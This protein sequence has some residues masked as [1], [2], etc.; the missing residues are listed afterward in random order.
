M[1]TKDLI[2]DFAAYDLS[3]CLADIEEIRRWNPQ[4]FEME[5]LTA[6]VYEDVER[7]ICVGYRDYGENEFWIRGHMPGRPVLPG[8][9]MCE[10]AAQLCGYFATKHDLM[11]REILGFGGLDDVRFRDMVVPGDRLVIVAELKKIRRGAMLISR[12]QGFVSQ[13][14]V[15]E[16]EIRGVPLP[17]DRLAEIARSSRPEGSG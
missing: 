11:G 12:F 3:D 6:I 7:K 5:Q 2:L 15:C 1:S 13:S 14:M 16:G 4:R 17:M 8:I 10:A 9:L